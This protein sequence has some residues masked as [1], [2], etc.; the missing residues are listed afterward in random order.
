MTLYGYARVSAPGQ[1]PAAQ[2]AELTAAGCERIF[3]EKMSAAGGRRRPQL[4]KALA[5]LG[6]G[7]VFVVT[8][9]NRLARSVRDALN[10]LE[11]V[12]ARGAGFRSLREGWAD[13]TTPAGRFVIAIFAGFA[14]FDREMILERT[15]EGRA[16]ARARGVKMGRRP[17]LNPAQIRFVR[18][19]LET[20][21][22]PTLAEL[23]RALGVSRSTI[24]RAANMRAEG[25]APNCPALAGGD[26]LCGGELAAPAGRQVDVEELLRGGD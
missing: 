15:A 25:H 11:T 10:S 18:K 17:T 4:Q 21:P 19:S 26:C 12:R 9:L 7:D 16:D 6:P 20:R 13:T 5:A 14:E 3:A 1:D 2:V 22:R 23:A 24:C 8:R